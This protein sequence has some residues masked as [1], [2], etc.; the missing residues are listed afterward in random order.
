MSKQHKPWIASLALSSL[1]TFTGCVAHDIG[2]RDVQS[3]LQERTGHQAHWNHVD[4]GDA[5]TSSTRQ[6]LSRPLDARGAAQLALLN[7]PEVQAAFEEL[8]IGRS[9]LL[10]ALALPNPTGEAAL[11]YGPGGG[12]PEVELALL[13][14]LS[15]LAYLPWK[16]AA[17]DSSFEAARTQVTLRMLDIVLQTKRAFYEYQ[18]SEQ[19]LR[20]QRSVVQ[21]SHAALMLAEQLREAG[22][23][24]ELS[25]TL[26]RARYDEVRLEVAR[27]E[28]REVSA[29]EELNRW[30]GLWGHATH[31]RAAELSEPPLEEPDLT[32]I[33]Q[34][35]L[36][37]S[38][39]LGL[40]QAEYAG[41]ARRADLASAQGVLPELRAGLGAERADDTWSLG[42]VVELEL[43]VFYQGQAEVAEAEA[44]M[45]RQRALHESV[46]VRVRAA[47]RR[48]A[49]NLVTARD[50]ALYHR[51]RLLPARERIV[52]ET[53]LAYNAMN[54]GA[55]ELLQAR[56]DQ[57]RAQS[58]YYD[59]LR[60]YWIAR[61]E[62]D[63]L[64]S[65]RLVDVAPL[66]A[67]GPTRDS[68]ATGG[69]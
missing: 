65:G 20:M 6:I 50:S 51:D 58:A 18:A 11:R 54:A 21:A 32:N 9:E 17:A 22:N 10:R 47:A 62:F 46:A 66:A 37:V 49:T 41:A 8:G 14:D 12:T 42:P 19:R 56:R 15:E 57:V 23:I 2:Y 48:A 3:A 60:D 43:P 16:K 33:E 44:Q 53:Q 45:R 26:E 28:A 67:V 30:L 68:S 64:L 59:A 1:L 27:A 55:F 25:L 40:V 63:Q 5:A 13:V 69:H 38:L 36:T 4:S 35:A 31:W 34:R 52:Q 7:N 39:D 24:T 61:A 29:R